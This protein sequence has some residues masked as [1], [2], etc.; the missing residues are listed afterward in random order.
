MKTRSNSAEKQRNMIISNTGGYRTFCS[1]VM[2][3]K[4]RFCG[5][6]FCLNDRFFGVNYTKTNMK[7]LI[8]YNPES[9][10][11]L[12]QLKTAAV[13]KTSLSM[14]I[15]NQCQSCFQ[16]KNKHEERIILCILKDYLLTFSFYFIILHI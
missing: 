16:L 7:N 5:L 12:D 6:F 13:N 2:S 14:Q 11:I 9:V 1:F 8:K 4:S 15:L 10:S 3:I